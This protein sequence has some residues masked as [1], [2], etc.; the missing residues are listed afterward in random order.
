MSKIT[1]IK[2]HQ[3][4]PEIRQSR[5]KRDWMDDTYNKHAYRCLPLSHA[6]VNGWEVILQQ[7]VKVIWAGGSSVPQIIEGEIYK[8][9]TIANCNKI[10]MIDFHIGWA[11][12]TDPGYHTYIS[13]S[14]NYFVDGAVPLTANIPS[15]WWPDEVQAGWKITKVNEPVIFPAGMPFLFFMIFPSNLME[16]TI[17]SVEYLW[18]KPELMNERMAYSNAKMSKL[19]EEPWTWMNGIR[20]GLN[21]K[22]ERI[23]PRH[24]GLPNLMSP[25]DNGVDLNELDH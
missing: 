14:P 4:S 13:G 22:G 18:D 21:E 9:R 16:Q 15:D 5:L 6:N 2:T 20:T 7:D 8:D 1:L 17:L 19:Q 23:G 12:K 10:G 25:A 11:F 24:D 3:I